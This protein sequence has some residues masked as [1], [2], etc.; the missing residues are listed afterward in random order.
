MPKVFTGAL[1]EWKVWHW[2]H[3]LPQTSTTPPSSN[4]QSYTSTIQIAATESDQHKHSVKRKNCIPAECILS[5]LTKLDIRAGPGLSPWLRSRHIIVHF[6]KLYHEAVAWCW[7]INHS[8]CKGEDIMG[9]IN[10]LLKESG[11]VLAKW[12]HFKLISSPH[13]SQSQ[14]PSIKHHQQDSTFQLIHHN[15][16]YRVQNGPAHHSSL[17]CPHSL[18]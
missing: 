10:F 18:L 2:C 3:H 13:P 11:M 5:H 1:H 15:P 16:T 6:E 7:S 12:K 9:R 8:V 4:Q 14:H 17:S